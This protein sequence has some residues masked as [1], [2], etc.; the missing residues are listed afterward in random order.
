MERQDKHE[1]ERD[2]QTANDQQTACVWAEGFACSSQAWQFS[3][4][5]GGLIKLAA[6]FGHFHEEGA[7]VDGCSSNSV[8]QPI[9][10]RKSRE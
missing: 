3:Q 10:Q 4:F 5:L 7:S 9:R 6:S 1:Q 2:R 8:A